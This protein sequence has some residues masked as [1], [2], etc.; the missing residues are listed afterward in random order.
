MAMPAWLLGVGRMT[1]EGLVVWESVMPR[2][3]RFGHDFDPEA[4]TMP[5]WGGLEFDLADRGCST[6]QMSFESVMP[7][8]GQGQRNLQRLTVLADWCEP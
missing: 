5:A 7:G 8:F 1:S 3:A 4:V 2:G 6:G